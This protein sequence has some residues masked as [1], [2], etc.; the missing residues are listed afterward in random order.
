MN[1]NQAFGNIQ[2]AC[3]E[4]PLT[5]TERNSV[6]E[7]LRIVVNTLNELEALK[8]SMKATPVEK[9]KEAQKSGLH[10]VRRYEEPS[11]E[12]EPPIHAIM[13][14]KEEQGEENGEG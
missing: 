8:K 4:C 12:P 9:P 6:N 10:I 1:L 14:P 13:E 5:Q 2:H 3:N 11:E 7:G